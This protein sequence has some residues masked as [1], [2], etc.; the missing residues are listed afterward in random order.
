MTASIKTLLKS[1]YIVDTY[2]FWFNTSNT[3]AAGWL[4]LPPCDPE[5]VRDMS[6]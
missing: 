3:P 1:I 5:M 6:E 4:V 2:L